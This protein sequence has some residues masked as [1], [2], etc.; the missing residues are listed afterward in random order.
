V[1]NGAFVR[2]A[3]AFRDFVSS[4]P[5]S[6]YPA[7][8]GRY[9]L[10]VANACP[11]AHRTLMVRALKGLEDVIGVSIVHPTF[12]PTRPGD[13]SD[14]HCGWVFRDPLDDP[15]ANVRGFGTVSCD[16][17]IPD[18]VNGAKTV[19]ELCAF[20][21]LCA[22]YEALFFISQYRFLFFL[23]LTTRE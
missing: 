9:H 23:P 16:D 5:G 20:G 1:S 19:R 8:A 18:T 14:D 6:K 4:E 15:V 13:A 21:N 7:E 10:Y 2:T 22:L 12:Q 17:C 3:S 11:W